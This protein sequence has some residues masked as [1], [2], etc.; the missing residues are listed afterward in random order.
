MGGRKKTS[1]ERQKN[2]CEMVMSYDIESNRN[3]K[4]KALNNMKQILQKEKE[5]KMH[6]AI[7]RTV[8][9][10]L[11]NFRI[12]YYIVYIQFD[13]LFSLFN[14]RIIPSSPASLKIV[15]IV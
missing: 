2:K 12:I 7:N 5:K 13:V 4:R 1:I 15:K 6:G 10:H 14:H 9:H 11:F 8:K 3:T